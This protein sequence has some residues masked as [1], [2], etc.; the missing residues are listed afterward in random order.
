MLKSYLH[1]L[2][3]NSSNIYLKQFLSRI[4]KIY[5][6]AEVATKRFFLIFFFRGA[7]VVQSQVLQKRTKIRKK[8]VLI[9]DG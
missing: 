6:F 1:A 4:R 3:Y 7:R 2:D 9:G 8:Y 5:L